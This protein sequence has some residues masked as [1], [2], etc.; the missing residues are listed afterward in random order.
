ML[1][2]NKK[3]NKLKL[4]NVM[5]MRIVRNHEKPIYTNQLKFCNFAVKITEVL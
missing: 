3:A 2:K 4:K 1:N 5:M